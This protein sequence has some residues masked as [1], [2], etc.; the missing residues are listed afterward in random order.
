MQVQ[1]ERRVIGRVRIRRVI[2]LASITSLFALHG[3]VY[4]GG[5]CGWNGGGGW[6]H[7]GRHCQAEAPAKV[8]GFVTS[9]ATAPGAAENG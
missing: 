1:R 3:C 7:G 9:A 2:A 4:V 8:V 5:G 6:H